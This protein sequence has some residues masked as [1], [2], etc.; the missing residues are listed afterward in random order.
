MRRVVVSALMLGALWA[1]PAHAG[2]WTIAS[3]SA[4]TLYVD[5]AMHD[6]VS[7]SR[8]PR[9][10]LSWSPSEPT[11]VTPLVGNYIQA[12]WASFDSGNASRDENIRTYVNAR[13][14]PTLTLKVTGVREVVQ[15]AQGHVRATLET[16]LYCN[17][18]KQAVRV[19]VRGMITGDGSLVVYGSLAARMSDF[20]IDPPSLMFVQAK[21]EFR[22]ET[23]LTLSPA[24]P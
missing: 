23:S 14:F 13:K 7:V 17:G 19:Q 1:A 8:S 11:D 22:V 4:I 2:P 6:V 5:H 20:G 10:T 24:G 18:Q 9:G 16:L 12:D 3:P 21:D 15:D